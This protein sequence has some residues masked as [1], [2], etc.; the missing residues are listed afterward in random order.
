[1]HHSEFLTSHKIDEYRLKASKHQRTRYGKRATMTGGRI[2]IVLAHINYDESSDK[3][4]DPTK[5]W[6]KSYANPTRTMSLNNC[7][8]NMGVFRL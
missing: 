4:Q 1:M 7:K 6:N 3:R 8:L 5:R 2:Q